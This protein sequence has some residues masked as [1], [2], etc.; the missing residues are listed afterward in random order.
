MQTSSSSSSSNSSNPVIDRSGNAS[1][2]AT[3]KGINGKDNEQQQDDSLPNK[4]RKTGKLGSDGAPLKPLAA[5][6]GRTKSAKAIPKSF[7]TEA[8]ENE[9]RL[10]R[11]QQESDDAARKER[12]RK[13][14]TGSA[15]T[16]SKIAQKTPGSTLLSDDLVYVD[17]SGNEGSTHNG[18]DSSDDGRSNGGSSINGDEA[19]TPMFRTYEQMALQE[20]DDGDRDSSHNEIT[21]PNTLSLRTASIETAKQLMAKG[22]N[23]LSLRTASIETAKQLMAKGQPLYSSVKFGP[24]RRAVAGALFML[25]DV[26]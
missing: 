23:M 14:K 2:N 9:I 8:L 17:E 19:D 24:A 10:R 11:Q 18:D 15:P 7:S 5:K 25:L 12:S 21:G 3:D 1:G 26:D 4:R 6:S 13:K 16:T 20:T 22:Q